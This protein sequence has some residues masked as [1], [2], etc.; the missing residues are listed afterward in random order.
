MAT[1]SII[2]RSSTPVPTNAA[3]TDTLK[4]APLLN[5]EIDMN[6]RTLQNNLTQSMNTI[7]SMEND[8]LAFAIALG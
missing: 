1:N 8:A 4:G 7:A 5:T 2:Y 3:P 6:F